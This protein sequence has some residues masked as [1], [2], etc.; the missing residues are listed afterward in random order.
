MKLDSY[1][2]VPGPTI[3]AMLSDLGANPYAARA[4][5]TCCHNFTWIGTPPDDVKGIL[6][7]IGDD[8]LPFLFFVP[9]V[10][11]YTERYD[12]HGRA[13][14]EVEY[15]WKAIWEEQIAYSFSRL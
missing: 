10:T 15:G 9:R 7:K 3:S 12:F 8:W 1:G 2:N 5:G 14:A 4:D 11:T 6:A 13:E